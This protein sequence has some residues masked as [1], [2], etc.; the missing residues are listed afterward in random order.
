MKALDTLVIWIGNVAIMRILS[1]KVGH[2]VEFI[3]ILSLRRKATHILVVVIVH[4]DNHIEVIVI[5]LLCLARSVCKS[6]SVR[7]RSL[8]HSRI[9]QLACMPAHSA[10]RIYLNTI[11]Q[12]RLSNH[13]LHN[14]VSRRRSADISEADK[15]NSLS[16]VC[17]HIA[18]VFYNWWAKIQKNLL[19][20]K[21]FL[22][23]LLI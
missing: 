12:T 23:L 22:C 21:R 10:G 3:E 9:W 19:R 5:L 8:N 2:T 7:R 20:G 11:L 13:M 17:T 4:H 14:A 15:E 6:V 1:H 18:T 16:F